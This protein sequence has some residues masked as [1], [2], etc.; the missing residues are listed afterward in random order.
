[1]RILIVEDEI[2]I[3][4][5]MDSILCS[6]GYEVIGPA[7][8]FES[9]ITMI[10]MKKPDLALLDIN[11]HGKKDGI[12]IAEKINEEFKI[13]FIFTTT[14]GDELTI[15]R[16]KNVKP[17]AYL[18]KPFQPEQLLATIEVAMI[19]FD[20]GTAAQNND[21]DEGLIFK[22]SIFIKENARYT[23]V[24]ID[25]I[26]W[27]QASNNYVEINTTTKKYLV[28]SSFKDFVDKFNHPHFMRVHRSYVV[29]LKHITNITS[30]LILIDKNEIPLA[31]N[32]VEDLMK[33]LNI[34]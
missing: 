22:D 27:L 29:N 26:R 31:P 8:D 28:R 14:L 33:K 13:P 12:D 1:M 6:N 24:K 34:F 21:T 4:M 32:Y 2:I 5:D 20:S 16:A 7:V 10:K 3:A 11:L 30:S 18:I 25:E 15:Q 9:A 17:A 23:K 19:N